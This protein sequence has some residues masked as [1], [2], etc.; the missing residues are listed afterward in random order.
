[1]E[2]NPQSPFFPLQIMSEGSGV[3]VSQIVVPHSPALNSSPSL[4]AARIPYGALAI[5][6]CPCISE[7]VS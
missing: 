2:A 1:V 7:I 4:I 3:M 5:S 6:L